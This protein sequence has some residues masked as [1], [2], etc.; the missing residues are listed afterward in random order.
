MAMLEIIAPPHPEPEG[1][2]AAQEAALCS[3]IKALLHKEDAVLVAHYYAPA[4]LQAL[5]EE[6]GGIVAD[7]LVMAQFGAQHAAQTLLVAGVYFMG[8]TAKILTP[9]KRILMPDL[10][11]TC[12]LDLGCSPAQF[13]A[14]CADYPD[15]SKVVYANT[16]AAVKAQ[17]DWVV[18]SSI[19]LEIVEHLHTEGRSVVFAPDRHLGHYIQQRTG[20][21]MAIYPG[22]CVVHDEFKANAIQTLQQR[23]PEAAVLVHPE[24][25]PAVIAMADVVGS[26]SAMVKAVGELPHPSFIVATD[27][28]I[29]HKMRMMAPNKQFYPALT[30][31]IS[32]TCRSCGHCPWMARN[33]LGQTLRALQ[34]PEHYTVNVA[35]EWMTGAQRSLGRMLD[36]AAEKMTGS[37]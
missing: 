24:S 32:A 16:S 35:Q 2:S 6:T 9:N 4:Q 34:N 18:T 10:T 29:L 22:A 5:A 33:Q 20:A 27:Q 8:E 25:P 13:S 1:L 17:A 31:G 21:E 28:G 15:H 23:H 30:G 12:S 3:E 37:R 19:A 7:S 26:T 36:F 11:A 14:F